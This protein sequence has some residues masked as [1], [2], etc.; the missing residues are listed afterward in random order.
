MKK[1]S[2]L[3]VALSTCMIMGCNS[4]PKGLQD[5]SKV[6]FLVDKED[7]KE[8]I[9]RDFY[10]NSFSE[11]RIANQWTE[12][13]I[14][15]PFV[16][17]Y[18]GMYY[19][20]CSTKNSQVGVRAYKSNDLIHWTPVNNG[21]LQEGYVSEEE[22]TLTAYAPEITH[23]NGK[24]YM[25]ESQGGSGHYMLESDSPEGPFVKTQDNFG[26]S[27]DGS[28]FIDDD[29]TVYFL[30]ASSS[31]IRMIK[32]NDDMTVSSNAKRLATADIGGWTEGPSL[33][34]KDDTYFLM[35]TGNSVISTGYRVGYAYHNDLVEAEMFDRDGF[36]YG[37]NLLLCT[38]EDFNGLGH[39]SAVMGPNMDSYYIAYHS[40]ES[41]AGPKRRFCVN[42]LMFNGSEMVVPQ[43]GLHDNIAPQ[44]PEFSA[45]NGAALTASDSLLLSD[46][47][48]EDIFTAEFNFVGANTK[49]IF[50]YVDDSN[51]NYITV[52]D[53]NKVDIK[54]VKAGQESSIAS[55][56]LKKNYNY[57]KLHTL[58]VSYSNGVL[59]GFF[60][61][62]NIIKK[63]NA[64]LNGGKIGY[65]G[66][67]AA[68]VYYTAF[69]NAAH[70]SSQQDDYKQNVITANS[71]DR[72]YSTVTK[73]D[74]VA[75]EEKYPNNVLGSNYLKF[76]KNT[77]TYKIYV[78]ESGFYGVD[79][80]LSQTMQGKTCQLRIDNEPYQNFKVTKFEKG[81]DEYCTHVGGLAI[82]K[83][84]HY[85]TVSG[86]LGFAFRDLSFYLSS[87]KEDTFTHALN[88]FVTKGVNYV[89]TWKLRNGGHYALSGNR[90]LLLFGHS[91]IVNTSAEVTINLDGAT[92]SNSAG[93]IL[94]A[95]NA[96]FSNGEYTNSIQGFY[97]GFN[98]SKVFITEC[99]YNLTKTGVA[100]AMKF[101]SGR[102]YV[103]KAEV[104]GNTVN[105]YIDGELMLTYVTEIGPV[106]G[107]VGLYTDGAA[108]TYKNLTI[109]VMK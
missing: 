49:C 15:D 44:M 30:R 65:S 53:A 60:D 77:A 102:D 67:E 52:S 62:M 104:I 29:E 64:S 57:S 48:S 45:N 106:H 27:I 50:S 56:S 92:L 28:F 105:C 109:K 55:Y 24:F 68:N 86:E 99:N 36:Y 71:F 66:I 93:L 89:N 91:G 90:Q 69:S 82:S 51:Y 4:L 3:M 1:R 87:N 37:D 95:S 18:N 58:R 47:A 7:I 96:S 83:G 59:D 9:D 40:L 43:F 108:A 22:C 100:D 54:A 38:D 23:F 98:N 13:G 46:K 25:C 17:R 70:D 41:S 72:K 35:F 12:Y 84:V 81:D 10:D 11:E 39:S 75:V 88:D 107:C 34:K 94:R 73:N 8:N 21:V 103:L 2:L 97:V 85:L 16:Y 101:E 14:G 20:Y 6:D 76:N 33:I 31:G 61:N 19:L 42:R 5:N 74:L 26:E 78:K 80:R 79:M 63:V 32:M